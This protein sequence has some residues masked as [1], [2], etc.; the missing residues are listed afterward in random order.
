MVL[1]SFGLNKKSFFVDPNNAAS[2]FYSHH[3]Y[4]KNFFLRTYDEFSSKIKKSL[5]EKENYFDH[6]I[7]LKSDRTSENIYNYLKK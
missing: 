7:C 5:T 6:K 4:N 1:E 2:T 3:D